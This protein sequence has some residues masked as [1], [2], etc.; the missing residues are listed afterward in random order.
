MLIHASL[1]QLSRHNL[2]NIQLQ[3]PREARPQKIMIQ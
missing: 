2:I 1:Q 3:S